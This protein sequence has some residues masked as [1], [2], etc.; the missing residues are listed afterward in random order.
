MGTPVKG[1]AA[2]I[3]GMNPRLDPQRWVFCTGGP[4]LE[5]ALATF[6]EDEGLSQI[7]PLDAAREAGHDVSSPMMRIVLEVHSALDGTG[8]TAAVSGALDEAGIPCN[9]VAAYHHDHVFV[10]EGDAER[11]Q[12]V[13]KRLQG[14]EA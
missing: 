7:L 2:M 8:L 11:A 12:E 3:A 14:S 6:R 13:L 1:R 5:E 10:P 9:M 4:L